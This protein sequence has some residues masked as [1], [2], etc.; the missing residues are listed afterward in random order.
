MVEGLQDFD[1]QLLHFG[2]FGHAHLLLGAFLCGRVAGAAAGEGEQ[3]G[4]AEGKAA[5]RRAFLIEH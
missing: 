4:G 5:P 2:V 3:S 1:L